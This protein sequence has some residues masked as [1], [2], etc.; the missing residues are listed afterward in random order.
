MEESIS[1]IIEGYGIKHDHLTKSHTLLLYSLAI[2]SLES[3]NSIAGINECLPI[4]HHECVQS[5]PFL[6]AHVN[7][8]QRLPRH[9]P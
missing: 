8:A 4:T 5:P 1:D 7:P 6:Q 3:P 9:R 2:M